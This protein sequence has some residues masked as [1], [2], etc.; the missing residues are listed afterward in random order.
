MDAEQITPTDRTL[1]LIVTALG[2]AVV[3][4][5]VTIVNVTLPAISRALG[6]GV[7]ALQWIVDA[8][9]LAFAG[10]LL[11]AGVLGD[12][13]G[14]RHAFCAGLIV[15][16]VASIICGVSS[17]TAVM[18]VARALQG[19]GG[20]LLVP[21]SLA[22][23]ARAYRGDEPARMRAVALWTAAG[24]LAVAAGP[25]IGGFLQA[26]FGWRS[27][28]L[29][30]IPICAIGLWSTLRH[31]AHEAP[32]G[33]HERRFNWSGL[34]AGMI[35]VVALTA[36]VIETGASQGLD[37]IVTACCVIAVLATIAFIRL[38]RRAA[39][40]V[41]PP[42]LFSQRNFS[43]AT[44]LG[45]VVN[46]TFYG[47][48][49]M[50]SLYFQRVRGYSSADT[51]LAFLPLTA[52]IMPANIF[53]GWA[54]GRWGPRY[55]IAAGFLLAGLGYG[56]LGMIDT[57]AP[58]QTIVI[59]QALIGIGAL[60]VPLLTS[61]VLTTARDGNAGTASGIFNTSRQIGGALG[62][63]TFGSFAHGSADALVSG[64]AL[65]ARIC[66]AIM[67][68]AAIVAAVWL[69]SV[70]RPGVAPRGSV[71]VTRHRTDGGLG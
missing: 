46:F 6:A 34:L 53:G 26:A 41:L 52:L 64:F 14:S 21:S 24:G 68:V 22:L 69:T 55:P 13:F 4:L 23:L 71:G 40:P 49:F 57:N 44:V 31:V 54:G 65:S 58:L 17:S 61:T 37:A 56:I 38:D 36:A 10:L 59:G 16:A 29:V 66:A 7:E 50:L 48:I 9:T 51:G 8:Y 33:L 15:F 35:A 27:I 20:A 19:V 43:V 25:V 45:A 47:L 39:A 5:D 60:A 42:A 3:A 28:F 70:Q 32:A 67:L 11:A 18:I 1:T 63:A 62:V 2:F 12:R 30:N